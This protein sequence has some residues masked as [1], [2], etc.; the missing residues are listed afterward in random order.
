MPMRVRKWRLRPDRETTGKL[1]QWMGCV[2]ATYNWALSCIKAKPSE[3]K[4]NMYWLRKRFINKCNIPKAKQYLLDT[5]KHVRDSALD[6]LVNAYKSN[7]EKR[8]N[9]PSHTFDIQFRSK[10]KG[11]SAITIPA[12]AI[13]LI[14]DSATEHSLVAYPKM[15]KSFI[16]LRTRERDASA[17]HVEHDCRL[18]M[19]KLGRFYLHVPQ[20]AAPARDKQAS[21]DWVSLDPGVRAFQTG[22]SPDYGVCFKIAHKDMSYIFRLC[23]YLDRLVSKRSTTIGRARRMKLAEARLRLRI[24][25]LVDE[26]H[27]KTIRFLLTRFRN[28]IIPPFEVSQMVTK[29]DRKIS[30]KT[31]RQMLTWRHYVFRQRLMQKALLA[32]VNVYVRTEE[33]T[34]KTCSACLKLNHDVGSSKT[35][36]CP[37]CHVTTDRDAN[38][39]RNIFLK[40]TAP[41]GFASLE[42]LCRT[43]LPDVNACL[44]E[45]AHTNNQ[46]VRKVEQE[47][48]TEG[49]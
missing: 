40:N 42:P 48:M 47:Y 11:E 18:T 28:I 39:S 1:K 43:C 35:F 15:L 32:D 30:N 13:K 8:R 20:E 34:T 27:W 14:H 12:A 41:S 7:F 22:Y 5:P 49:L 38:G 36:K 33:Y 19:D 3:Y 37:H 9:D 6:D 21:H 2:R 17:P 10:K 46:Q 23:K 45:S 44:N 26:V 4:I 31:V 25:H 16:K 24:K 29:N